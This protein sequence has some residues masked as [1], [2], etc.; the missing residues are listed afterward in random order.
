MS[1]RFSGA[2]FLPGGTTLEDSLI[3]APLFEKAGATMLH[4]SAGGN[5]NS[6][7]VFLSYLYPDAYLTDLAAAI[8]VL[9]D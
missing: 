9:I 3:Q 8:K 7:V 6:E 2:D 1:V 5:D 4:V